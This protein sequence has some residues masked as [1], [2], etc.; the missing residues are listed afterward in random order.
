MAEATTI[1][2]RALRA[3]GRRDI[4]GEMARRIRS[5]RA[6]G[7]SDVRP[8]DLRRRYGYSHRELHIHFAAALDEAG[9]ANGR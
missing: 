8:A 5:L 3:V 1:L 6:A 4:R 2:E 9:A 7:V